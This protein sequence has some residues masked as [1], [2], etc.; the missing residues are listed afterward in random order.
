MTQPPTKPPATSLAPIACND[1]K[2]GCGTVGKNSNV[3]A[4]GLTPGRIY[5]LMVGVKSEEYVTDQFNLSLT[6]GCT[7][8]GPAND[9]CLP[10]TPLDDGTTAFDLA[11]ATPTCPPDDCAPD[12]G[13]RPVVRLQV[14]L[15]RRGDDRHLLVAE[16]PQHE[17]CRVRRL[18]DLSARGRCSGGLQRRRGP[19]YKQLQPRRSGVRGSV[20]A[21][22]GDCFKVRIGDENGGRGAGQIHASSA[23]DLRS[24]LVTFIDP[25]AGILDARRPHDPSGVPPIVPLLGYSQM[26]VNAPTLGGP[27][28]WKFCETDRRRWA[29]ANSI[30]SVV[31]GPPGTWTLTF[32]RPITPDAATRVSYLGNAQC[33]LGTITSHPGNVDSDFAA[34]SDDVTSL[35][36]ALA[37]WIPRSPS[38][39]EPPPPPPPPVLTLPMYSA[40]IDRSGVFGPLDILDEID[41]LKGAASYEPHLD[42]IRPSVGACNQVCP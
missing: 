6:A 26:V 1:D 20:P 21:Q 7:V 40:D 12:D 24:G 14:Q 15:H 32:A 41:L 33:S 9:A 34:T 28:C 29:K 18:P 17:R 39:D 11:L 25:P 8:T 35:V 4:A 36:S 16:Q 2:A 38:P 27:V 31:Q 10:G 13:Q 23:P 22:I 42:T 30:T 37:F 19:R 5:Y 3:C